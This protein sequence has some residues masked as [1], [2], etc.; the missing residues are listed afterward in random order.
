MFYSSIQMVAQTFGDMLYYPEKPECLKEFPSPEDMKYRIIISTKPPKEYLKA[1][2]I[3]ET[4]DKSKRRQD[5]EE[6][7]WG[8]EPREL[9]NEH[10]ADDELVCTEMRFTL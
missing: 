9:I 6:D 7:V 3:K 2:T 5:S 10:E 1:K 8:M 4:G